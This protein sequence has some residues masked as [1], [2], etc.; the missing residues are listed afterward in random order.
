MA[1]RVNS[2]ATGP[3]PVIE[4]YRKGRARRPGVGVVQSARDW[5]FEINARR[6]PPECRNEERSVF[7]SLPDHASRQAELLH[8]PGRQGSIIV[9]ERR[10]APKPTERSEIRPRRSGFVR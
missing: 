6:N 5:T 8:L 9:G 3:C 2:R 4:A 7:G 1:T 10:E